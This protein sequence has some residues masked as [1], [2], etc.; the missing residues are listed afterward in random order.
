MEELRDGFSDESG[1]DYMENVYISYYVSKILKD[2]DNEEEAFNIRQKILEKMPKHRM[3]LLDDVEYYYNKGEYDTAKER[4]IDF[5]DEFGNYPV[6]I[7]Y[8][9]KSNEKLIGEYLEKINQGNKKVDLILDGFIFKMKNLK[10][11]WSLWSLMC[12]K[13]EAKTSLSMLI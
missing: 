6:A 10:N 3:A 13:K 5:L 2:T 9:R 8:M 11:A 12:L 1:K 4:S 7:E